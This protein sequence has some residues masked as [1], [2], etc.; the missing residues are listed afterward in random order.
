VGHRNI[1]IDDEPPVCFI[2]KNLSIT[3]AHENSMKIEL[4]SM[5][6]E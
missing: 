3:F 1:G 6:W 5:N 2:K 4:G